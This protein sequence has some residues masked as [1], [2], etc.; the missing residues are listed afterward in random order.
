MAKGTVESTSSSLQ[1]FVYLRC[2]GQEAEGGVELAA[3]DELAKDRGPYRKARDSWARSRCQ[4]AREEQAYAEAQWR[5]GGET[6]WRVDGSRQIKNR[7]H[8]GDRPQ[9]HRAHDEDPDVEGGTQDRHGAV[10]H[11]LDRLAGYSINHVH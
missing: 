8:R 1:I 5:E 10:R 2:R 3:V 11:G 6:G 4:H 9:E 7:L